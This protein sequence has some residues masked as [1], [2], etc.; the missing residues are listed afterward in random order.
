MAPLCAAACGGGGASN[1]PPAPLTISLQSSTV[2]APQDGTQASLGVTVGGVTA[3]SA[4]Q[5]TATELPAGVAAQFVADPGKTSG[6]VTFTGSPTAPAGTY[7]ANIRASAGTQTAAQS[8]LLVVAAVAAVSPTVDTTLGVN[9]KLDQFM[10]TSFQPADWD[11][12]FFLDH[13]DTSLL[14]NLGAKHMRIQV[15]DGSVPWKANSQPQLASDW[16]FKELD[17]TVQP[18][19]S[20]T[21]HSPE[22]QIAV[23]PNLPGMLDASGHFIFNQANLATFV[24]YCADLVRYYNKG[25]FTWG[26]KP[27][28]SASSTPVIWWGIYNEYNING[29]TPG[30]YVQLYNAVVPAMLAVDNTIKF[31]AVEL[32]D[33]D[34]NVGDPRNNLPTFVNGVTAQVDSAS[35]HFYSSCNQSDPDTSLFGSVPAFVGDVKYFYQQLA[36][37]PNLASVPVWVTEN[38]VNADYSGVNGM[39]TCNPTQRFVSDTRGTS[40][41]FSAW[42]PYVF[43]QLGKAGNRALY[44]WDYPAD[45]QYGEVDFTT[46]N[47]YLSYWV[48]YWLSRVFPSSEGGTAPNFLKLNL[49]DSSSIEAIATKNSDGSVVVMFADRAVHGAADNN[50]P[51]DP[52]TVVIDLSA[53]GNFTS[54]TL[55]TIDTHTDVNAGPTPLAITPAGKMT[56]TLG[57]YGVAFL[58]LKR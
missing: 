22:F 21:D 44:H 35:T 55:L 26:G 56:L 5:V 30:Q 39:S 48:D 27:F 32:S 29:L 17:A 33:F 47:K 18:V 24:Q 8:F 45:A 50:G 34:F 58:T 13:P 49:T 9:G 7:S 53:L 40:A 15:L 14:Q 20:V 51:G 3:G 12:R 43:S 52:R 1:P 11:W 46:G 31:S 37:R 23:P 16:D 25:G 38:N 41:F 57:G 6:T 28:K 4:F 42:R 19:L 36:T 2:I 10:A 54:A